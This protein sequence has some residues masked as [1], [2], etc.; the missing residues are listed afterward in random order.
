MIRRS[1]VLVGS[2]LIGAPL[3]AG[4]TTQATVAGETFKFHEYHVHFTSKR[5][6]VEVPDQPG[7][8][9]AAFTSKGVGIRISRPS[10]PPFK[11]EIWGTGDY[12]KDGSGRDSGYIR[13]TFSDGS[14]YD[15][16]WSGTSGNGHDIGTTTY[17]NGTG[18]FEGMK[19]GEKFDCFHLGDSHVCD[20]DGTIALP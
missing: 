3:I 8:V 17:M 18:R 12:Q 16:A 15:G 7:H 14:S 13:L 2:F 11:L 9:L 10:E 6:K 20:I 4:A 1:T 19:G 5:E